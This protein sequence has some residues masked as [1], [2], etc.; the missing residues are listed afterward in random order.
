M[1]RVKLPKTGEEKMFLKYE[2]FM[3]ISRKVGCTFEVSR[4]NDRDCTME[5]RNVTSGWSFHDL[6]RIIKLKLRREEF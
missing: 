4:R 3:T 1:K 2:N 5:Y 6:F